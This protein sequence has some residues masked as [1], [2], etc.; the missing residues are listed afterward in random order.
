MMRKWFILFTTTF[1]ITILIVSI[2]NVFINNIQTFDIQY[3]IIHACLSALLALS[4]NVLDRMPIEH[5]ILKVLLD[6]TVIFIIVYL[7]GFQLYSY[8][9]NFSSIMIT[10][11]LVV[12]IYFIVTLIYHFILTKEAEE[13]SEK[14]SEWRD[15]HV[16]R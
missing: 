8:S 1:T 13:M 9:I 4:L 3:I 12:I 15:K 11:G 14:I 2:A 5:Y 10:F 6:I 16:N 7:I